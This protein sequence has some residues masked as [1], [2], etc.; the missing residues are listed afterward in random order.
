MKIWFRSVFFIEQHGQHMHLLLQ[1]IGLL[2][3]I[4]NINGKQKERFI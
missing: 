3:I 1:N 2:I 4:T